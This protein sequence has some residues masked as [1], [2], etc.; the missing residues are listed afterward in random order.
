MALN[1]LPITDEARLKELLKAVVIEVLH[2]RRDLVRDAVAEAVEELGLT[3]AIQ[4]GLRSRPVGRD[5]VFKILRK[6]R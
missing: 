5:A 4:K 6:R 3:R 2:E 1:Q